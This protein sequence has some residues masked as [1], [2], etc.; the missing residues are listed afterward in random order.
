MSWEK[1]QALQMEMY[2]HHAKIQVLRKGL[3]PEVVKDYRFIRSADEAVRLSELFEEH[4]TLILVHNMGRQCS[5]CTAW[6]DGYSGIYDL[7]K[8][9]TAFVVSSPDVPAIQAEKKAARGWKFPMVSLG[10]NFFAADMGFQIEG[11]YQPGVSVFTLDSDGLFKR[12]WSAPFGP[13]DHYGV[14]WHSLELLPDNPM[15]G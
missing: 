4:D 13:S 14:L 11:G 15:M 7:L 6:A 10:D 2:Q 5:F 3:E 1:I 9:H 12:T 8:E